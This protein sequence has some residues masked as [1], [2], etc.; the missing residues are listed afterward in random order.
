MDYEKILNDIENNAL[1]I[2]D[3]TKALEYLQD[4][5]YKYAPINIYTELNKLYENIQTIINASGIY[6]SKDEFKVFISFMISYAKG[7]LLDQSKE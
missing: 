5:L 4:E 1:K 6:T 7:Y 2:E 3:Y